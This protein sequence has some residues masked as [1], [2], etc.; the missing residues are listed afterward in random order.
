MRDGPV[1]R[2]P[3]GPAVVAGAVDALVVGAGEAADR[4]ERR[5]LREG[6]LAE[7]RMEAHALPLAEPER[8][9]L[10]P[11]GVRD[12]HAAEVARER[13]APHGVHLAGGE[14]EAPRRRLGEV[15]DAGR[16]L[17]EPRR[18]EPGERGEGTERGVDALVRDPQL[19]QRLGVE[20][21]L[22]HARLV[23]PVEQVVEVAHRE[24][25]EPRL[26]RRAVSAL[27]H[28]AGLVGAGGGEEERDVPA[29]VQEPDR[30]RQLV[31]ADGREAAS[32]PA[33][34]HVLERRLHA[35][36][37]LEPAGEP[38]CDLAHG[39]EALARPRA[40]VCERVGD[41]RL[42]L[43][44]RLPGSDV[45]AVEGEHLR[46]VGRVD[47]EERR[48]VRDVVVVDLDRLV[49]VR[50]AARRVEQRD[51]VGVGELGGGGSRELAEP[52]REH[53]GTQRVLERL[54]GAEIGRE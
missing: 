51:V 43:L 47:Q 13:R 21:L 35:R 53:G 49:A 8:A 28:G 1:E 36:A 42:A 5:R 45:R 14:A 7:V 22:P 52:H 17:P 24:V 25:G 3:G 26:V 16:V 20:R 37:E 33:G 23:E 6:A 15:G 9:G 11:D 4:R 18:L 38:L 48:A 12:A 10:L 41:Q 54:A 19:R 27:D 39:R 44:R 46:R 30:Q 32:V 31:A 40:G 34:E 29:D 2:L 50:G